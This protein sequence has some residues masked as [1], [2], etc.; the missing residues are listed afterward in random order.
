M[1]RSR[2]T[3]EALFSGCVVYVFMAACS[4][5]S[6][7]SVFSSSSGTGSTSHGA[8][9]AGGGQVAAGGGWVEGWVA[10]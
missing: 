10:I 1:T 7:Q 4:G 6:D 5:S 2:R 8:T 3:L 9:T